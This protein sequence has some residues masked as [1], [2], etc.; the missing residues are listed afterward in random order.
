MNAVSPQTGSSWASAPRVDKADDLRP[1]ID[2]LTYR[3]YETQRQLGI[4]A[5]R[6]QYIYAQAH[7]FEEIYQN[8]LK[9]S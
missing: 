8:Y 9:D 3:S 1:V 6:L 5:D 7:Q 4:S 2:W